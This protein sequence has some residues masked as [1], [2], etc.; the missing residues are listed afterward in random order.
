MNPDGTQ[1]VMDMNIVIIQ[2]EKEKKTM[3]MHKYIKKI[4]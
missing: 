2:N 3:D 4:A 1:D